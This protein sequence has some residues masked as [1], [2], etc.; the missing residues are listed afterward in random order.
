MEIIVY[1][2][3]IHVELGN[4]G[5]VILHALCVRVVVH[6][7]DIRMKHCSS[8]YILSPSIIVS[9]GIIIENTNIV[10]NI[11]TIPTATIQNSYWCQFLPHF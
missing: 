8:K 5:G 6:H 9:S 11:I 2:S 7:M 3:Y 4:S 10:H 1:Y